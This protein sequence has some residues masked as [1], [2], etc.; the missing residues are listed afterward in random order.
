M[1]Y[2]SGTPL[3][4]APGDVI[5]VTDPTQPTTRIFSL[6]VLRGVALL[7][8]LIISI[9]QFGGFSMN[10]QTRIR[11]NQQGGNY[12]LLT[13]ISILF[14][15][16]MRALFSLVFGAGIILFLSRPNHPLLPSRAD[17]YMKK[18]LWLMAFGILNA[19][20]LLWPGDILFQYGIVGVLLFAMHRVSAKGL[21]IVAIIT[22]LIFCG[23]NFWNYSDDKKAYAKY[24]AIVETEK[25][26]S[27]DSLE[28]AK[29][30]S[31]WVLQNKIMVGSAADSLGKQATK[32]TSKNKLVKKL[33]NDSLAKAAARDTLNK[34]QKKD[35]EKWQGITK[36]LKYD[37]TADA[38]INKTMRGSY[39]PIW[40]QLL[41]QT[42]SREA[43]WLYRTGI[44]DIGSMMLL[45]MA[46]LGFGFFNGSYKTGRYLL[47]AVP[48]LIIGFLLAWLRQEYAYA[49][50]HDYTQY[51]NKHN[52]PWDQFFPVER[53][54]LAVGYASLVMMVI[55]L[56]F[57]GW[58]WQ[59]LADT[60]RM[61]FTN[62]LLQTV[63][64][65]LFFY[66]YGLGNYGRLSQAALYFV[67][68]EIW[69]ILLVFSVLW[70]RHFTIGPLEWV[71]RR[72][73]YGKWPPIK[74]ENN[75]SIPSTETS[76][77]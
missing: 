23:K 42:Q 64:C 26:F 76:T 31:V 34:Q 44:W 11:L 63:F 6:D 72:L 14:E 12:H 75:P 40:K 36:S 53:A 27:K 20:V 10:E 49:R 67:V 39:G 33:Q 54:L 69:L 65:T 58:L 38:A 46:L 24:L 68:V 45:G 47:I 43:M 52:I 8:I 74:K 25:K 56:R 7:G 61:A 28:R 41:P 9:W 30:D 60:G 73:V 50:L 57:L 3:G 15:G 29:L 19:V 13:V 2:P 70:F 1:N 35:K 48:A 21:L 5:S 51:I 77:I 37:S 55:R 62:Y 16:K 17:L 32:D 66:G 71:W 22:T 59:A 4:K 18:Q